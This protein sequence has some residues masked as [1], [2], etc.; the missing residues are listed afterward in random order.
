MSAGGE[1]IELVIRPDGTVLALYTDALD[2][3]A[4]AQALASGPPEITRAS[5]VEPTPDG[6]WT[7]DLDPVGGP[8]LGPFDLRDEA[9]VAERAWLRRNL[10]GVTP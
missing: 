1:P 10:L 3:R 8:E 5:R 2:F 6:R 4:L 7:A 9:L